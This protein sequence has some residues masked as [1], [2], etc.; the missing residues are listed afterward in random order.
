M[1]PKKIV[2]LVSALSVM[3]CSMPQVTAEEYSVEL[4][5][6]E[7]SEMLLPHIVDNVYSSK[8]DNSYLAA[9]DDGYMRVYYDGTKVGIEYY[10]NDLNILSAQTLEME[11]SVWGGFY[12]GNDAYYLVEGENNTAEDDEAE[13]IRVIKYDF[14]WNRLGA[15]KITG[16]PNLFGGEVRYPFD[17]SNVNFA[18][19]DGTLCIV[20]GHEGYVDD[21]YGQGHQ[22]FLM[23]A[24]DESTMEGGIVSCDLWHSFAQYIRADGSDLY[25]LEQSDGNRCTQLSRFNADTQKWD[26]S[27][28]V[29]DYGGN[30]DS[31]WAIACYATVDGLELSKDNVLC[32]GGSID[33]SLYDSVREKDVPYNI[34]LTVTPKSDM[35]GEATTLKW[36]TDYEDVNKRFSNIKLTKIND[37]RFLVSWS[38]NDGLSDLTDKNDLFSGDTIHYVFIDG[39]GDKLTDEFT[40]K[41]HVSDCQPIVKGSDVTF[42]SSKFGA[43]NFYIIDANSGELSKKAYRIAGDNVTWEV[44]EDGILTIS[45]SGALE[46]DFCMLWYALKD[47]LTAVV[48]SEGITEIGESVFS[49]YENGEHYLDI[50]IPDSVTSIGDDAF[51]SGW[52]WGDWHFVYMTIHCKAGSYAHQYAKE[53]GIR[54]VLTDIADVNSDGNVNAIDAKWILQY[55]SGG[56]T[57][58]DDQK[59]VADVNQDGE[60]NAIDAKWILQVA[61]GSRDL[62]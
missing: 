10:D 55:V 35:S 23:I 1:K 58:T 40:A 7:A 9:T 37:D 2:A 42:F 16:D 29:L 44:S 49:G 19:Y 53:N 4:A 38:E 51:W 54:Y 22:G 8:I 17:Y 33:Q 21:Y 43:L 18:E 26:A 39:N 14:D 32:I 61:S 6:G 48:I 15:A 34:Y 47:D 31:A 57:L 11:L 12:K 52:Y 28:S 46:Q 62:S 59:A 45:G 13:V 3:I 50:Y 5:E 27:F 30:K 41:G 24:V 36:L 20:T 25:V 60:V 56:R